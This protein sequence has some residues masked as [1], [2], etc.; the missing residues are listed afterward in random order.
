M[1]NSCLTET[2]QTNANALVRVLPSLT[3][4]A[5]TLPIIFMFWKLGGARG[6]LE[7][8]TGWHIRTGEWI[9]QHG[10]VPD[11]DIFSFTKAG[12]P[13]F[14]WEWLWDVLF[15][16]VHRHLGLAGV[17]FLSLLVL[18][19]TSVI[20]FRLVRRSCPN[21][22]IAFA[23][24]WAAVAASSTHWLA[25]PHL[26]TLLLVAVFLHILERAR[27]RNTRVLW[28]LPALMAVWVNLHGGF[29]LGLA[30]LFAYAFADIAAGLLEPDKRPYF[31]RAKRYATALG[32]SALATLI[33]PYGYSLHLH[34]FRTITDPESPLYR[35][36]G[37]WQP[38][39]LRGPLAWYVEPVIVL[40]IAGAVWHLMNRRFAQPLLVLAF[41]H[42]SFL[43]FRNMPVFM[44]IAAPLAAA[45]L[46]HG[47]TLVR[48]SS[49]PGRLKK[50]ADDFTDAANDF[51]DLDRNWRLHVASAGVIAVLALLFLA[52]NP[53]NNLRADYDRDRYPV[54]A[55]D[56]F[57]DA[58]SAA[59][60]TEDE[61]GD[62]L[63]YRLY[64]R[65][66]VFVDGRFDLYGGKFTESYLEVLN[67][68]HT[69]QATLDKH[70]VKTVLVGVKT[71]LAGTLKESPRWQAVYDDGVAILFRSR[72]SAERPYS[73]VALNNGNSR[74]I[75]VSERGAS[76]PQNHQ[77]NRFKGE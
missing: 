77:P 30:F 26:F 33:N 18:C 14:A 15:A 2:K 54:A 69:W 60:F 72:S 50:V 51:G 8:D 6:M 17:V 71:P 63:I 9:L 25:R 75:D 44:F 56:K 38:L 16:I 62:Y 45:A 35:F 13:W 27:E 40:G 29:I 24:T 41:L 42:S 70:A 39:A 4:V 31:D 36:V 55:V 68:N 48:A 46:N 59:V 10:R 21:I 73:V 43:A 12:E 37:E 67:S 3:D 53:P 74:G 61:W 52:P 66:K 65:G 57:A 19:F 58:L 47:I 7:G 5:F 1:T 22:F 20:V 28:L 32:A 64:P 34:I 23:A 11:K 76:V 49:L